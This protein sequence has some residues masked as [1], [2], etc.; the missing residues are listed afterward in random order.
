MERLPDCGAAR[1]SSSRGCTR[2]ISGFTRARPTP[3]STSATISAVSV[4]TCATC[5]SSPALRSAACTASPKDSLVGGAIQVLAPPG[6]AERA[7]TNGSVCSSTVT[8]P[9]GNC[10]GTSS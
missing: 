4:T 10:T 8:T 7:S 2:S 1:T 5:W 6:S 3:A 9:G